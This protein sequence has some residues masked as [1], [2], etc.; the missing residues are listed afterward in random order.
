[1][2]NAAFFIAIQSG[3]PT[4]A[5]GEPGTTKTRTTE[6]FAK[7]KGLHYECIIGSQHDPVDIV[8]IPKTRT[9]PDGSETFGYVRPEWRYLLE[10]SAN[11]GLLHL[12]E[13]YDSPPAV[14][15]AFLQI[16]GDGI[17]RTWIVA[18]GNP[19][20]Q[21][22]NGFALSAPVINRL[23]F[24]DWETPLAN[25]R[26]GLLNGWD[27]VAQKYPLL[28]EGWQAHIHLARASILAFLKSA[29]DLAQRLPKDFQSK[30]EPFP[31]LRS[32]TNAATLLA[33]CK[34][35]SAGELIEDELLRGT[36]GV[37]ATTSFRQYLKSLDLQDPE[38]LLRDP[39]KYKPAKLRGDLALQ[40]LSAVVSVVLRNNTRE[41]W[42]AAWEVIGIQADHA[43]DVAA[44]VAPPLAKHKPVGQLQFG[45]TAGV[46]A[47]ITIPEAINKKLYPVV[48]S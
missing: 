28:L 27:T 47:A 7:A 12:D 42:L 36:V 30:Q 38:E 2:A 14:Q 22:T 18:T 43:A 35:I 26:D 4:L 16:L 34:S 5:V 44:T 40:T 10:N 33:A 37:G 8:G 32:W 21:S 41:R 29:P 31:S 17:P 45:H 11:G 20:E 39:S 6:G 3:I 46:G 15:A 9:R 48:S 23:C 25:W 1:M 13:L 24:L 19:I